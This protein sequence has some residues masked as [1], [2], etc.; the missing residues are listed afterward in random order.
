MPTGYG[1]RT[2]NN[3]ANWLRLNPPHLGPPTPQRN[4][5]GS[6]N[7]LHMTPVHQQQQRGPVAAASMR[8]VSAGSA[9]KP[10]WNKLGK[11]HSY[12]DLSL[13]REAYNSDSG[14]GSRSPTPIKHYK[15][16]GHVESAEQESRSMPLV[17]DAKFKYV[18]LLVCW[19]VRRMSWT[20]SDDL[21]RNRSNKQHNGHRGNLVTSLS[22]SNLYQEQRPFHE[23]MDMTT[24]RTPNQNQ[25][26]RKKFP[27]GIE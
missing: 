15:G 9:K 5:M 13:P 18:T 1:M 26:N 6:Q 17:S 7:S 22:T 3:P 2:G 8:P 24:P 10:L 11:R 16:S 27:T 20:E 23:F 21:F 14:I 4:N 19:L 25:Q 12:Q